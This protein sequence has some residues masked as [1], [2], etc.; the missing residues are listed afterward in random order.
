MVYI[1][2]RTETGG[3]QS[4][5]AHLEKTAERAGKFAAAFGQQKLGYCLGMAHDIGKYAQ[6]FQDY[7][8]DKPGHSSRVDH[9]TAGAKELW[10]NRMIAAAFCAA[11]HHAGLPD[12]GGRRDGGD[13]PTLF[14]RMKKP[15]PDYGA[16]RQEF[17]LEQAQEPRF[18]DNFAY[19]MFIRML[20]SCLV[21][22]DFLDTE[23]FMSGGAIKRGG[24]ASIETL[25]ARLRHE[26]AP[27]L[28]PTDKPINVKRT[29]ILRA[30]L[31]V[32][33]QAQGLYTLT[34]PTGGGKTVSSL[35][36]A[37]QHAVT[38]G[39]ERVI[40]VIPYTS[41]VEQTA[42]V[43]ADIVG[44]DN[45]LAHHANADFN[46]KDDSDP[47]AMRQRLAA[48]NWDI[49]VV[50]TTNVQFFESLF[51]NKTSRCRKLHN[52]VNSV[53]IFDEAQMLPLPYLRPCVRAIAELVQH[54]GVTA[55]LCTA[56]QPALEPFFAEN[57]ISAREICPDTAG[58]YT[59]FRRT[60][61]RHIGLCTQ[62]DLAQRMQANKQALTIVGTRKQAAELFSLLPEQ[63][64]FH[65][66]TLMYPAH[67]R[68]VLETIRARLKA[69]EP[70]RLVA[71]SLIEAGVDVD[72]P[73]AF[74]AEAGLDSIIQAAGRCNREGKNSAQESVVSVYQPEDAPPMLVRQ[75]V[76]LMNEVRRRFPDLAAP[77]AIHA[78]FEAVHA[79]GEQGAALDSKRI[80]DAFEK[81]REGCQLPFAQVARDCKLIETETRCVLIPLEEEAANVAAALRR[82]EI[83]RGLMRRAG[84]YTV[85]IYPQHFAALV[86]AGDVEPVAEDL[87]ILQNDRLYR[88]DTGL[89]L[90]A[91]EGK[92]LFI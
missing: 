72:F 43:F 25:F 82:G 32:G 44:A 33:G 15:V 67:R 8:L 80:V 76:A 21:D 49:P 63:G 20:F 84:P 50:V 26:I 2:H 4:N 31:R 29:E 27:W 5:L 55:V 91:D 51:A 88:A 12:G 40:Y 24:Y 61:L 34:V 52:I 62:E 38:H 42:R 22:A 1:A 70:C 77:E 11:G 81:G 74:R 18:S 65:L 47:Q 46:Q 54:Y 56:T 53:V 7:I 73:L 58:L 28:E 10:K 9:S 35:A 90:Q 57:G 69:K 71:T 60:T 78:Y 89:S 83:S 37:L 19:S 39:L 68:R 59:F 23:A 66:S 13:M 6:A 16:Y 3:L 64:R 41:I 14:G 79:L 36:F 85:N 86:A 92:A 87:G 75:Q 17:A 45:V 30:C 48:E